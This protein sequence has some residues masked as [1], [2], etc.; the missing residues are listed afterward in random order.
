MEREHRDRQLDSWEWLLEANSLPSKPLPLSSYTGNSLLFSG[1]CILTGGS[2]ENTGGG[3]GTMQLL[4]STNNAGQVVA[5]FPLAAGGSYTGSIV[6]GGVL[7]DIGV[8][9]VISSATILGSVFVI[10]LWHYPETAPGH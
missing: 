6:R 10:P 8:F 9:A 1:R 4:D 5:I 3:A 7:I 2:F